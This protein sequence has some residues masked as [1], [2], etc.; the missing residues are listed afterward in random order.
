M[1][2]PACAQMNEIEAPQVCTI[3]LNWNNWHDT[4]RCLESLRPLAYLRLTDIIVCDN[5]SDDDS[6]F[7]ISH[8]GKNNFPYSGQRFTL[9]QSGANL[10]FGGGMN[11]GIRHALTCQRYAFLWLLNND[12][13]V[14]EAS[15]QA[16]LHCAKQQPQTGIWGSTVTDMQAP[17]PVQTAG[18]F[19]YN[20]W[21]TR[22][23]PHFAGKDA[24]QVMMLPANSVR[25]DY[26]YGAAMFIRCEALERVGLL[27][28]DYFLFYEELDFCRR[29][30]Q[31]GYHL[32]WCPA[33]LVF[34]QGSATIGTP[35][36]GN[37]A[38]LRLANYYENFNSL[39]FTARFHPKILPIAWAARLVLKSL[40]LTVRGQF[41]LFAPLLAAYRDFAR[42]KAPD[43]P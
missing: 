30:Q 22:I 5:H 39:R 7:R 20:P 38:K 26:V 9:L 8:W 37:R 31:A 27:C 14:S 21:L 23:R 11:I 43:K 15:L 25:L 42:G 29:L 41:Y 34:H 24:K 19:L 28:E 16:L 10:G 3:V 4:K 35:A 18:G 13:Q 1:I 33:S 36:Q 2:N 12:T 32:S 6:W 17:Y 40:L